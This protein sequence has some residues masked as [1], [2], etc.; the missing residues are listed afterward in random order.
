MASV[1]LEVSAPQDSG[2]ASPLTT[3]S[4]WRLPAFELLLLA[5]LLCLPL[6]LKLH[7]WQADRGPTA[8][9][10]S[11]YLTQ[12]L[13]L[14]DALAERGVR[15]LIRE[16]FTLEAINGPLFPLQAVPLLL[17]LGR[18]LKAAQLANAFAVLLLGGSVFVFCRRLWS[19]EV[20]WLAAALTT[21]TPI[22]V[23]LGNLYLREYTLTVLVAMTATHLLL[24]ATSGS[25]AQLLLVGILFGLGTLQRQ[26]FAFYVLPMQLAAVWLATTRAGSTGDAV[27]SFKKRVVAFTTPWLVGAA[28]AL[29]WYAV[30]WRLVLGHA[31]SSAFGH[32]ASFYG[33]G[34]ALSWQA[35]STYV[36][37]GT[38]D[39]LSVWHVA[40]LALGA[41]SAVLLVRLGRLEQGLVLPRPATALLLAWLLPLAGLLLSANRDIRFA[42]PLAPAFAILTATLLW[43]GLGAWRAGR[44]ALIAAP[45]LSFLIAWHAEAVPRPGAPPPGRLD[46][47]VTPHGYLYPPRPDA[48]PFA[49][50][51]RA[52]RGS[53]PSAPE[54]PVAV[55][56]LSDTPQLNQSVLNLQARLH[57]VNLEIRGSAWRDEANVEALLGRT[58]L[59][60]RKTGDLQENAAVPNPGYAVFDR[61]L[62]RGMF[63]EV[64]C[65]IVLPD[66]S[67]VRLWVRQ[68]ESKA[69]VVS[70]GDCPASGLAARDVEFVGWA[71]LRAVAVERR[72]DRLVVRTAWQ[73]KGA[74]WTT[75]RL[76]LHLLDASR[77]ELANGDHFIPAAAGIGGV[78]GDQV[79]LDSREIPLDG[80]V[81]AFLRLGAYSPETNERVKVGQADLP[82]VEN[83]TAVELAFGLDARPGT[84]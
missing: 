22:L 82:S 50:L 27:T 70:R 43:H 64:A 44:I 77:H 7:F 29:P 6:A 24:W 15:G 71:S 39:A 33:S 69:T 54:D 59:V 67:S 4:S 19:R 30:S 68:S 81:P 63:K 57:R 56:V 78:S 61:A 62:A 48:W 26:I 52:V 16:Y 35:F 13:R 49:E 9:D 42:A 66:G 17:A 8:W 53:L 74:F 80:G 21:L 38:F 14:H 60:L 2:P 32:R 18:S 10:D 37:N 51:L 84:T 73:G 3:T 55:L 58:D 5:A 12:T 25:R 79:I 46:W 83:G 20:A 75:R 41:V 28:I 1:P 36:Q 11:A 72:P 34:S 65:P 23:G 47:L 45:L 40:L 31:A 76:F